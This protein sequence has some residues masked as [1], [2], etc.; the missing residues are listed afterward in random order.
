MQSQDIFDSDN[1]L[2]SKSPISPPAPL[3][4]LQAF[5]ELPIEIRSLTE[6]FVDPTVIPSSANMSRFLDSLSAKVHPSPLT[7]DALSELFQEFYR[8]AESHIAT[9][10]AALSSKI[11]R[12]KPVRKTSKNDTPDQGEQQMLT[13]TE[14]NNRKKARKL[15]EQKKVA[16][17]EAVEKAVCEK[18]YMKLWHHRSAEDEQLDQK[19]RSRIAA[20]SLVGIGLRE[21]LV[22]GA[23]SLP[24]E[25][26]QKTIEQEDTIKAS[27]ASARGHLIAM[28][29]EKYPLGKLHHLQD[30][31][32]SIVET[33]TSFFP[34]SSSADEVLPTLIY[35]LITSPPEE[36]NVISDLHFI[37]RFRTSSKINGEADY[38]MTNLEAAISFLETIEL[39]TLRADEN[40]QGPAKHSHS[41]S[42]GDTIPM[43]LGIKEA[44]PLI[45]QTEP[46]PSLP[47]TELFPPPAKALPASRSPRRLSQII[48][49]QTNRLEAAGDSLRGAVL[50]SADQA[51]GALENS[52]RF[53]FGRVRESHQPGSE[54]APAPK[55]LEDARKLVSTP[56]PAEDDNSNADGSP[57]SS[58]RPASDIG[59][60]SGEAHTT[61]GAKETLPSTNRVLDLVGGRRPPLRDR[62]VDSNRSGGSGKRVSFT[63]SGGLAPALQLDKDPLSSPALPTPPIMTDSNTNTSHPI[64]SPQ[65]FLPSSSPLPLSPLPLAA[66]GVESMRSLGNTLNPLNQFAKIGLFGRT[67][68]VPGPTSAPMSSPSGQQTQSGT[69]TPVTPRLTSAE[70]KTLTAVEELKKAPPGIV[71]RFM[72]CRD[73]RELRVG[74][75]EELL[76]EYKKLAAAVTKVV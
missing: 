48:Q 73:A 56:P 57:A 19:L 9:H 61:N 52:L 8:R 63:N 20:L 51:V 76:S 37:Q 64:H 49:A 14:I 38:C 23:E 71:R 22:S 50:D 40:L 47:S 2:L 25:I 27:L 45:S 42:K 13:A 66:A 53:I 69:A 10:V 67:Q 24:E 35:T 68:S 60:I 3:K 15:L 4:V 6:R 5:D 28:T 41:P 70:S 62:S 75:I 29:K 33:L 12:E 11:S 1:D 72:D 21:L 39:S 30:A 43:E 7:I 36:V 55:T 34:T 16:L 18:V 26:C 59:S 54:G 65:T 44:S 17:E 74:E 31:H 58:D 46:F 32:K